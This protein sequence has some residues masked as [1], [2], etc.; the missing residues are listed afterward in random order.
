LH[1]LLFAEGLSL[2]LTLRPKDDILDAL[3]SSILAGTIVSDIGQISVIRQFCEA[4]AA[5]HADLAYDLY[6][7]L[8]GFYITSAEG[9]DLDI[10][11]LDHNLGRDP[12]Q[13]ASG[14]VEVTR[15]PSWIDDIPFPVPHVA[16]ATLDDG[17]AILYRSLVG[18]VLEASG[19]SVS[20]A[21]PA[22]MLTGGL[23]DR[24]SVN[25]DGDGV[26]VLT[27]G[28]QSSGSAIAAA[29]QAAMRALA[30]LNPIHQAAYNTFRCDFSVTT[31]GGYTLRS[32]T[33]GPLSSVVVTP[34]VTQDA[35]APLHLG[36][37]AGGS[38]RLGTDSV[39]L[40]VLC[41]TIGSLGNV[42]A[43]Q[44]TELMPSLPGIDWVS[45]PL[46][47]VNG[48]EPA[49]DDA[50]RQDL[51]DYLLS[52]GRG[53]RDAVER[54]VLG[55][56]SPRDGQRHVLSAQT[57]YGAGTIQVFVCD[58]QSLTVG[59]QADVVQDV[60]DELD[61]RGEMPGGWIPAGS[62]AGV[63]PALLLPVDVDVV[64]SVGPT[65]DILLAQRALQA[66]LY[67][68]LFGWPVGASLSYAQL[69]RHI[70]DTVAEMLGVVYTLPAAFAPSGSQLLTP[71]LGQKYMPGVLHV[72]VRRA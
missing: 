11:G 29:I 28:T 10:R 27:L 31:A 22:L 8:Q 14:L 3:L 56:V 62:V 52:L 68:L 35:S 38:E 34:T 7:L 65:P 37:L 16:Q 55:T 15:V 67:S 32:G 39:S 33:A 70:D 30:A 26:R 43:G 53:T 44:I 6:A 59:A 41:D 1:G 47:L 58:G 54:A 63:A 51:R 72:T 21:G 60:Q 5:T 17:T 48:R 20:G 42:G 9:I 25:V 36:L 2:P 57:A 19:R 45:N 24:L 64:V 4:V 40:T 18:A 61:G 69:T 50:Y 23:N 71:V 66:S 13:G 46:A 49:S 12:G